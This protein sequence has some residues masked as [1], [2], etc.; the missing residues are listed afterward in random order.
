MQKGAWR[1]DNRRAVR[2]VD[3]RAVFHY[4]ADVDHILAVL[5]YGSPEQ[6]DEGFVGHDSRFLWP[7]PAL[8]VDGSDEPAE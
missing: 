1:N 8:A 6:A 3:G 7:E 4:R 5:V 2:M